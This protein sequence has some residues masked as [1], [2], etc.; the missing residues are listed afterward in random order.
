MQRVAEFLADYVPGADRERSCRAA[1][2]AK[3][4]L[5]TGM[6]GEFPELQGVMGCYYALLDGEDRTVADA[7][8]EHYRPAGPSDVCPA[9]PISVVAA[10]ADKIDSLVAL[11][12]IGE[13]PTGSRDP[14]GL[15]R[16]ALGVIRLI[17]E[18]RLRLP[19][20]R[21]IERAYCALDPG[22]PDPSEQLVAF[23]AD[24]L[25]LHL[26]EQGTP[27]NL[28]SAVFATIG[29]AEAVDDF[30]RL[31]A[32]MMALNAF[33]ISEDGINLLTAYRRASNI[34][35]IEERKDGRRYDGAIDSVLLHQSEER[36]LAERLA[37][38]GEAAG[39]F[40]QEE[41]FETAMSELARLRRPVDDFFDKVTVNCDNT[42]LRENRLHLL[43]R[44]RA[45]LNQVADFSQIEG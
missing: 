37:E 28:I 27:H 4:D 35:A 45:T 31:F 32:R 6:V 19:L 13:K 30:E 15:R 1:Q 34:V 20:T 14:F 2:L 18:N 25:K 12:A 33:L 9:A 22:F 21:A 11:F 44:I 5:S 24:R 26:R 10:L 8:A 43:S 39:T 3:A 17:L 23:V 16:A 36:L 40:L 41:Q 7:I 38:V 29:D 42:G